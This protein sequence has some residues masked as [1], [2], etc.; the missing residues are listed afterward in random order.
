MTETL[1]E[2][3]LVTGAGGHLGR[4]VIED[5]LE[6]GATRIIATTR[7]PRQ[8]ADLAARGVEVRVADFDRPD[9]LG[10]AFKDV[11]RLLLVS[12]NALHTPGL[13]LNQQRAAIKAATL[14]GVRHIL[15]TS[16]PNPHPTLQNSV[17]NDHFWTETALFESGLDWTIL[18]NNLYA[19]LMLTAAGHAIKSGQLVSAT[20]M[21]GRSYVTRDD[22][23][24]TAA[25]ALLL[26]SGREIL[27]VTGPV[28]VTQDELAAELSALSG[29]TITHKAVTPEAL[30][31]GRLQ[32]GLPPFLAR[33]GYDFD[34]DAA[35]G[36]H[37]IVTPTVER[38]SGR[39]PIAPLDFLRSQRLEIVKMAE[40]AQRQD[41]E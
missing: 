2:R 29:H 36:Y 22:C 11:D 14:S 7:D 17:P 5:L 16:L 8:L 15:Y 3:L 34:G 30:E 6:R 23:A 19:E 4:K 20:G 39:A 12:T 21:A 31:Q 40:G 10:S 28:A 9:T 27:D 1:N 37:A 32:S 35:Q 25:G 41:A 38:F 33:A 24:R 13:R 26:G 18:R